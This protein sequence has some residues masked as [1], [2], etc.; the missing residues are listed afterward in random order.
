MYDITSS[1]HFGEEAN[2]CWKVRSETQPRSLAAGGVELA[3]AL[4]ESC[5]NHLKDKAASGHLKND[6]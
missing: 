6:G 3:R 2:L 4:H 1:S 5:M